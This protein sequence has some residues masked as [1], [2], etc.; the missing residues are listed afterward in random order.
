MLDP[1]TG[2][3]FTDGRAWEFI[4]CLMEDLHE[5]EAVRLRHPR[6]GTGYVMKVALKPDQRLLYVKVELGSGVIF[7]RSFHYSRHDSR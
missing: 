5:V 4:A 1:D 3:P 2:R 6:G 7:G